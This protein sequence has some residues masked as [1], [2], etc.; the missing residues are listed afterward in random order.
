MPRPTIFE[1]E[2]RLAGYLPKMHSELKEAQASHVFDGNSQKL[3]RWALQ[4]GPTLIGGANQLIAN[5]RPDL[6]CAAIS[7]DRI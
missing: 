4:Y 2:N 6:E 5:V 3:A 1:L 7:A